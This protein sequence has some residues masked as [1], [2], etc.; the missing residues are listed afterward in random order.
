MCQLRKPAEAPLPQHA[1]ERASEASTA[2]TCLIEFIIAVQ[3]LA[4]Q[5]T[6]EDLAAGCIYPDVRNLRDISLLVARAVA[7]KVRCTRPT[8]W[9]CTA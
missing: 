5:V 7:Q 9:L 4:R 2:P 8:A 6:A 1:S 3:A